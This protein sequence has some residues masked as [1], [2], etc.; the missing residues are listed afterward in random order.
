[1]PE[2]VPGPKSS[3]GTSGKLGSTWF[4]LSI[5]LPSFQIIFSCSTVR[6]SA[7]SFSG[8]MTTAIPSF[9]TCISTHS[10]P[11]VV[12]SSSSSVSI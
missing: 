5:L 7:Q 10:T 6:L 4:Q 9:A 8:L 12:Q 2:S 3:S 11:A 1:M